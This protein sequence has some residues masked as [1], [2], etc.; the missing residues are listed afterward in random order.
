MEKARNSH[1]ERADIRQLHKRLRSQMSS[2]EVTEKS[3]CICEKLGA[4]AWYRESDIIYGYY[5]LGN[6]V[7]CRSI[8]EQALSE[9][10][11]VAL[12]RIAEHCCMEFYEITSMEQVSEGG[13]HVMEPIETCPMVREK[14]AVVL[15]PGVVFDASGNRYGYGKGYYDRYFARFPELYKMALA[16]ENQMEQ[17]LEVLDTD[18]KMDGVCTESQMYRISLRY[19]SGERTGEAYGIIR[20]L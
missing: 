11:R 14:R 6:E 19:R 8:L 1:S 3:R 10:K 16:Y 13:F 7:D 2:A 20:D 12:P 4:E 17:M 15:V 9:G 18:V 5:P